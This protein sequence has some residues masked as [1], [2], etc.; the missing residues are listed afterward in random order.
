VTAVAMA[1]AVA[2]VVTVPRRSVLS[3]KQCMGAKCLQRGKV[4]IA[5]GVL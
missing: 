4:E 5:E 1:V 2:S 3:L